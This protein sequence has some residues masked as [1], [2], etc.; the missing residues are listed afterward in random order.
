MDNKFIDRYVV[1]PMLENDM[2]YRQAMSYYEG[3][4]QE[5]WVN[6]TLRRM[7]SV[8]THADDPTYNFLKPVVDNVNNRMEINNIAGTSKEITKFVNQ[9]R[10]D[11]G[12]ELEEQEVHRRALIFGEA[13]GMAWPDADG[14]W[15]I[16]Y[17][18]PQDTIIVYDPE[19]PRK[20][21]V[22][23][24]TWSD[25]LNRTV[26]MN[27][28]TADKVYKFVAN[29]TED[30][31][32]GV[33]WELI[34]ET[35][36]PFGEVPL[37][38]FRTET[39]NGRPE[40]RDGYGPQDAINKLVN[41]HMVTVDFQG[42]PQRWALEEMGDGS[43]EVE[44]FDETETGREQENGLQASPGKLWLLKNIKTVGE[45][46]PAD[47]AVFWDP[48]KDNVSTIASLTNT[49]LHYFQKTGNV[50]SGDALRA[51]EAPLLKKVQQRKVSFG[52][53]WRQLYEFIVR[54]EQDRNVQLTV[55]WKAVE[56][57]DLLGQWDIMAK[58]SNV[59]V[60]F[61]QIMREAGYDDETIDKIIDEKKEQQAWM[62]YGRAANTNP[63]V[64]TNTSHTETGINTKDGA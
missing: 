10:T 47:P 34:S 42:A 25:I 58:K 51:A 5:A 13:Y 8:H 39:P 20:K 37:F 44:D 36:N 40:H 21:L 64:R 54:A 23:A 55:S 9:V 45:F 15:L 41:T 27:L 31:A 29:Q 3:S 59:G 4:V 32:L 38:H 35:E 14:N 57:I 11:N 62:Q 53:T 26:R 12:M 33:N 19:N 24:R 16:S 52:D 49:P 60:S 7:L 18:S 43:S 63:E 2:Y 28:F 22:G 56:S 48:I 6:Q 46:K 1:G 50:P 30:L 61:K 17:H